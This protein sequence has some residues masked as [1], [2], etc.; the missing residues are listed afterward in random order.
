MPIIT[1]AHMSA[2]CSTIVHSP[3]KT[4]LGMIR[5]KYQT[6]STKYKTHA[7]ATHHGGAGHPIDRDI[8]LHVEDV[9]TTGLEHD[10][11]STSGSDATITLRI[12]EAEEH[13]DDL[14]HTNQ[15][16]LTALTREIND[17]HQ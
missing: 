1:P 14:I 7:M 15:A 16:K 11:E 12:P 3:I 2:H 17:L 6:Y 8:N 9:E 13:P 10:N 5:G 4:V